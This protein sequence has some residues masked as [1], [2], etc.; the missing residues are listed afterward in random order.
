[1]INATFSNISAISWRPVLEVEEAEYSERTTHHG[2]ATGKLYQLRL[3]IECTLFCT[4]QSRARTH[5]VLVIELYEL[6]GNPITYL[7][8]PPGPFY[9]CVDIIKTRIY[10][11]MERMWWSGLGRWT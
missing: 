5:A 11:Y 6:L 7:I 9:V 10:I 4:L 3:R 2:Q 8:E 1:M